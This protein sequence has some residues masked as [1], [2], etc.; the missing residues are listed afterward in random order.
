MHD[1]RAIRDNPEAFVAGWSSR[2]VEDAADVVARILALD[3]DQ[4]AAQTKGQEALAKRVARGL[5]GVV[6]R[7]VADDE[8]VCRACRQA[9]GDIV[10]MEADG[11]SFAMHGQV[12]AREF[13][14]AM[15]GFE[16]VKRGDAGILRQ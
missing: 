12:A 5:A 9:C 2:G 1:I 13:K 10:P 4:R 15:V 8:V 3:V 16:Q 11:D 14:R 7:R 6:E